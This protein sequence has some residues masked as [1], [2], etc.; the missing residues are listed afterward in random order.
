[1]LDEFVSKNNLSI[2]AYSSSSGFWSLFF[3]TSMI[4]TFSFNHC[5]CKHNENIL[6][7]TI[8]FVHKY[9]VHWSSPTLLD[10]MYVFILIWCRTKIVVELFLN[11]NYHII[12]SYQIGIISNA[13]PFSINQK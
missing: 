1:V 11:L 12:Y 9:F 7:H 6:F 3:S 5:V 8:I 2:A 4:C 13:S 10:F